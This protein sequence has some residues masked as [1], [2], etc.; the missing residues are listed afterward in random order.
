LATTVTLLSSAA[1]ASERNVSTSLLNVLNVGQS[2]LYQAF[3]I[4]PEREYQ[5]RHIV[6]PFVRIEQI[7]LHW[8]D[9]KKIVY[10]KNVPK[11]VEKI[12]IDYNQTRITGILH[13]D[14]HIFSTISR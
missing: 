12:A 2:E 11:T 14:K 9:L 5:F 10:L 3:C 7:G 8:K 6:R 13:K 4:F 1:P